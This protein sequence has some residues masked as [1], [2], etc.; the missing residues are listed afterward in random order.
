MKTTMIMAAVLVTLCSSLHAQKS[1]NVT[2]SVTRS[3][4]KEFKS[5]SNARWE[6]ISDEVYF[7]MFDDE[8]ANSIAYFDKSGELLIKGQTVSFDQT[9]APVQQGI[10]DLIK[11]YEQKNGGMNVILAYQLIENGAAKY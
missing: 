10:E 7:V 5:T 1:V 2:P 11:L 8:K 6:K 3:F 4:N 9:P